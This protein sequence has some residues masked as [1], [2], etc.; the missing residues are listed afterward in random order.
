MTTSVSPDVLDK[1]CS[2]SIPGA[3]Q[4]FLISDYSHQEAGFET[5]R[6]IRLP[7]ILIPQERAISAGSRQGIHDLFPARLNTAGTRVDENVRVTC[8]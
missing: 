4:A 6:S 7:T 2:S 3:T 5:R 1:S 8:F